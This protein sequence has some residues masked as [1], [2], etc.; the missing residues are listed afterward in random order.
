MNS[1]MEYA[2]GERGQR[3]LVAVFNN[4]ETA[5]DAGKRLRTEGFHK[6][7]IGVTSASM[8]ES[9]DD[10]AGAKIG[11]FL[12]GTTDG[13]TLA[14]TLVR[15]GVSETEALR[16]DDSIVLDD[17]IL[18][19]DGNNH[20]E[21]AAQIIEDFGGDVLSGESFV[22]TSIDW[23]QSEDRLGSELLG[24]Q[25]PNRYARGQRVDDEG[26]T[27]LRNERLGGDTIPTL[28]EDIFIL[29]FDDDDDDAETEPG[30]RSAGGAIGTQH[31]DEVTP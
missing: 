29:A 24:Y 2:R 25:D 13:G 12:S 19:V 5:H 17:V 4:R 26:Y 1:D 10:S 23:A 6:T 22:F 3:A 28:R 31:R 18:T 9:A 21:L 15:H 16:I 30:R 7:W 14:E 27:R 11:R 8:L 20:P